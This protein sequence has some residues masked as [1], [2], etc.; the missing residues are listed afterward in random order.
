MGRPM[1]GPGRLRGEGG[2]ELRGREHSRSRPAR[3]QSSAED[4]GTIDVLWLLDGMERLLPTGYQR[5]VL[6]QR[7]WAIRNG[8][9]ESE[10]GSTT[11]SANELFDDRLPARRAGGLRSGY[12]GRVRICFRVHRRGN[13]AEGPPNITHDPSLRQRQKQVQRPEQGEGRSPRPYCHFPPT[14]ERESE[15]ACFPTN[16]IRPPYS[17]S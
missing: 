1:R 17:L 3:R 11:D 16:S 10:S 9:P 12:G 5:E 14:K 15:R 7:R 2:R 6:R 8:R 4:T 13:F